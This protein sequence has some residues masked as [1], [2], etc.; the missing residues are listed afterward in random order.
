M[1]AIHY[2]ENSDRDKDGVPAPL[3][4]VY[5]KFKK[6]ATVKKASKPPDYGKPM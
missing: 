6:Q 1:A 3:R 5:P 2:N 4:I